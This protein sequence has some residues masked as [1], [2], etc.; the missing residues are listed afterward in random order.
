MTQQIIRFKLC[1]RGNYSSDT[2]HGLA[3]MKIII[4]MKRVNNVKN[5]IK[6]R[7]IINGP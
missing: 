3:Q 1:A 7:M 4:K 5:T 2:D 6:T